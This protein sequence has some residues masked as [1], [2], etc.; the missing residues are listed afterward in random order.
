MSNLV[1]SDLEEGESD[2]QIIWKRKT[3]T[4]YKF[5]TWESRNGI[6][7]LPIK[8]AARSLNETV[9][10]HTVHAIE[11][12]SNKV[13]LKANHVDIFKTFTY[14]DETNEWVMDDTP[15]EK[16]IFLRHDANALIRPES[17]TALVELAFPLQGIHRVIRKCD[18]TFPCV[19]QEGTWQIVETNQSAPII[20]IEAN[21]GSH[22]TQQLVYEGDGVWRVLDGI[23]NGRRF[24][25][26]VPME[27]LQVSAARALS[28][29]QPFMLSEDEQRRL[30]LVVE[31]LSPEANELVRHLQTP[32]IQT[33][34]VKA[35]EI[36][37]SIN[38]GKKTKKRKKNKRKKSKS[39]T[40][41]RIN[42]NIKLKRIRNG[43]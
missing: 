32:P 25:L 23:Q 15:S 12:G 39:K 6:K 16:C 20:T 9:H 43:K 28:P 13:T 10:L 35:D 19:P 17:E 11:R 4:P 18:V 41:T 38:G 29:R 3:A 5:L 2:I 14:D 42:K 24:H 33:T 36:P 30:D 7:A 40:K 22:P 34:E 21:Y 8:D 26:T 1:P 37:K 31:H 27:S